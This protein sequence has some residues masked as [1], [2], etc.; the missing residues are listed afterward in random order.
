MEGGGWQ[1]EGKSGA[2]V[3]GDGVAA[4]RAAAGRELEGGGDCRK[5]RSRRGGIRK[6]RRRR[7]KREAVKML[8]EVL[9][10]ES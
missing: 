8:D 10:G 6:G 5:V 9:E 3:E 7:G 1:Q 4:C 2:R